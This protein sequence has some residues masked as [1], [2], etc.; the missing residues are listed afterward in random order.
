[1][2]DNTAILQ[3][4]KARGVGR[5]RRALQALPGVALAVAVLAFGGEVAAQTDSAR[6]AARV[7]AEAGDAAFKEGKY[8]EAAE[9]FERAESMMHAPTLL[10][11]AARSHMK[12]GHYVKAREAYIRVVRERMTPNSPPAYLAAQE[13]A[14]AELPDAEK[15]LGRATIKVDGPAVTGI[16][17]TLDGAPAP[18]EMIGLPAPMDPGR[19]SVQIAAEGWEPG[20]AD[21]T[22][23]EQKT[24][25]VV[26]HLKKSAT[27]VVPPGGAAAGAVPPGNVPPG[28]DTGTPKGVNQGMR[29]GSYVAFGVGAV[30][31]GLGTLFL[32]QRGSKNDDADA[33]F[34]EKGCAPPDRKPECD[35]AVTKEIQALSDDAAS[36]GT[37]SVVSFAAG[38]AALITGVTLFVLSGSSGSSSAQTHVTPY[39]TGTSAGVLGTF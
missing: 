36:K 15:K 37:L 32:I 16:Q 17:V 20:S 28:G 38:G 4:A 33:L 25:E 12:L 13:S 6:A 24:S 18:A 14:K 23:Q 10:L 27:A 29:I 22:V 3:F 5:A 2:T 30:G 39:F 21:F 34:N 7:A 19:H 9:Y 1:L 8:Q 26:V 31:V 35:D 11:F